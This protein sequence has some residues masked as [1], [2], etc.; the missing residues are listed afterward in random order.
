[1]HFYP[2][3]YITSHLSLT[4]FG[5]LSLIQSNLRSLLF[6]ALHDHVASAFQILLTD[7][8]DC[9]ATAVSVDSHACE[10]TI[11]ANATGTHSSAHG[12]ADSSAAALDCIVVTGA[13]G[14]R[15]RCS[16]RSLDRAVL[17]AHRRRSSNSW[18]QSRVLTRKR[19]SSSPGCTRATK[20]PSA[21]GSDLEICQ[22]R[23][24]SICMAD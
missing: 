20:M 22:S 24:T 2:I 10:G 5:P 1:M 18:Q 4:A 7:C 15:R 12:S 6:L 21:T 16:F 3:S 17:C 11:P 8:L 23:L 19:D 13:Y 9:I 14:R